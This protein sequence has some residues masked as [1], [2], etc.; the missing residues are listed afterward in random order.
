MSESNRKSKLEGYQ[1]RRHN[2]D[3]I[4]G[5]KALDEID[6]YNV[7]YIKLEAKFHK[8][9]TVSK[10]LT[11]ASLCVLVACICLIYS[12]TI[13]EEDLLSESWRTISNYIFTTSLVIFLG[14]YFS[15]RMNGHTRAWSRNR[16]MLERLEILRR[17][18]ELATHR[19]IQSALTEDKTKENEVIFSNE[20]DNTLTKLFELEAQNRIETHKDIVGDYLAAH[21]GTFSWIKGLRK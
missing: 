9:S 14:N 2:L 16:L 21:E 20:Q 15:N 5:D 8:K 3:K 18:Y 4:T 1:D 7:K 6:F 13:F 11:T 19:D 10:R 17:E 12:E